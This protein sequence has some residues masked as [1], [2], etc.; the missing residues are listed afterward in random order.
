MTIDS[1]QFLCYAV[2][3]VSYGLLFR[4][5]AARFLLLRDVTVIALSA[6]AAEHFAIAWYGD[7]AF[8]KFQRFGAARHRNFDRHHFVGNNVR[9]ASYLCE[10]S[11]PI[12]DRD[13]PEDQACQRDK[14]N[15]A[16]TGR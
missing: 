2:L 12:I 1:F 5:S 10:I 9:H 6:W 11:A 4:G 8:S 14:A 7:L 13:A 3:L 16:A 15:Y